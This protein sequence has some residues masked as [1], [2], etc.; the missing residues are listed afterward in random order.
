MLI[1]KLAYP[2]SILLPD[3]YNIMFKCIFIFKILLTFWSWWGYCCITMHWLKCLE[4]AEVAGKEKNNNSWP[5]TWWW[6]GMW[7]QHNIQH[8]IKEPSNRT[9]FLS[10]I[11]RHCWFAYREIG[12]QYEYKQPY[13]FPGYMCDIKIHIKLVYGRKRKIYK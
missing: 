6:H 4:W 12:L 3:N 2:L 1:F 9:F 8:N 7:W 11:G 10:V 5:R 13:W